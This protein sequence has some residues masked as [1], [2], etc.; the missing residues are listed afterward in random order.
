L[1]LVEQC[2]VCDGTE[3][4]FETYHGFQMHVDCAPG[5][6]REDHQKRKEFFA[7]IRAKTTES[8]TTTEL[9]TT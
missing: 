6:W 9:E 2:E 3:G 5:P 1:N 7:A 4:P 8:D